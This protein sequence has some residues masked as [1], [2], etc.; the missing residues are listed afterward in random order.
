M[1]Q[2]PDIQVHWVP[3]DR[4]R[5]QSQASTRRWVSERVVLRPLPDNTYEVVQGIN[6]LESF[7]RVRAE[8]VP[9]VLRDPSGNDDPMELLW[10]HIGIGGLNHLELAKCV[11]A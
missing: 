2:P 3:T 9:A 11:A 1:S 6:R 7:L 10:Q 4:I 5:P 8:Y